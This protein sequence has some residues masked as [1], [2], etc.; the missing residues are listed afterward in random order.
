MDGLT[1][2]VASVSNAMAEQAAAVGQITTATE[3]IRRQTDQASKGMAEQSRAAADI[4]VATQN[5]SKQIGLMTRAN[6]EQSQ[7]AA[8]LLDSL[9]ELK[10]AG[11]ATARG[12]QDTVA[13][14]NTLAER[15]RALV[16][17][18]TGH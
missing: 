8:S 18:A 14:T 5:V 7:A 1:K 6:R 13:L 17:P 12:A 10:R 2:M 3:D 11:A 9:T 16:Q 4:N 15:T